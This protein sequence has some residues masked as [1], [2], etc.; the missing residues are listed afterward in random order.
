MASAEARPEAAAPPSPAVERLAALPATHVVLLYDGVCGLCSRIVSF[1][2]PRDRAGRIHFAALQG[3]LAAELLRRH[4][5]APDEGDPQ[6]IVLVQSPGRPDER[7]FFR[8]AA[9]L[10]I[11]R[12]LPGLWPALAVLTV[13]PRVVRDWV[14]DR[15]AASR[16]RVFGRLDACTLPS[17]ENRARF[18]D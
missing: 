17:P 15:V 12:L 16:Y 10:R 14:Y 8:S 4:G 11:A 9:A 1:L 3:A 13:V 7:L 5:L 2:L 6:S 18:L